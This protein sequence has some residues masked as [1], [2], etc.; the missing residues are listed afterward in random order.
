MINCNLAD[1]NI[2]DKI[3]GFYFELTHQVEH[4]VLGQ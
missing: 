2:N 3:Y 1:F 4:Q